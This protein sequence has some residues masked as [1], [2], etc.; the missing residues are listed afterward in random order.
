VLVAIVG[1]SSPVASTYVVEVKITDET[2]VK[3]GLA[4][5]FVMAVEEKGRAPGGRGVVSRGIVV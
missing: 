3:E 1:I 4:A 5:T 2:T